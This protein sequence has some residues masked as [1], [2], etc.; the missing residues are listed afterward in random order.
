MKYNKLATNFIIKLHLFKSIKHFHCW[1]EKVQKPVKKIVKKKVV[2]ANIFTEK[3][4]ILLRHERNVCNN[5]Q[6][7]ICNSSGCQ[8]T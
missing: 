8:N 6:V 1:A 5:S 2:I 3:A 7:I 4:A